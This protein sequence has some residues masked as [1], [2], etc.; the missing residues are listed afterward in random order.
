MQDGEIGSASDQSDDGGEKLIKDEKK[1]IAES[2]ATAY[3]YKKHQYAL[4]TAG[5]VI[6]SVILQNKTPHNNKIFSDKW[7]LSKLIKII[8][9]IFSS[10]L[11][12]S[13]KGTQGAYL[14]FPIHVFNYMQ[15]KISNK[16]VCKKTFEALLK[17]VLIYKDESKSILNNLTQ[18]NALTC[19]E[20]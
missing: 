3:L 6:R 10:A 9:G 17:S 13:V 16:K 15:T 18:A 20:E 11:Q 1:T 19:S 5:Q 2:N 8:T 14:S 4:E 7:S 12:N